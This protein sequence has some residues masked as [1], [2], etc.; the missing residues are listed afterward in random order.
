MREAL[1]QTSV[2]AFEPPESGRSRILAAMP[3]ANYLSF[4]CHGI[5]SSADPDK[6]ALLLP[7]TGWRDYDEVRLT[8]ADFR[9]LDLRASRLATLRSCESALAG[10]CRPAQALGFHTALIDAGVPAVLAALWVVDEAATVRLGE[11]M[12]EAGI[13]KIGNSVSAARVM[14]SS[15]VVVMGRITPNNLRDDMGI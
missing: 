14:A 1:A 2:D 8:V 10:L 11:L 12:S 15:G 9:H 5:W 13:G 4:F 6:S 3:G 7:D